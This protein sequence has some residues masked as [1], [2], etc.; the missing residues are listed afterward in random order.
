[1][2]LYIFILSA[3]ILMHNKIFNRI[4]IKD[5]KNSPKELVLLIIQSK[6]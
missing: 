5:L 2:S 6:K 4:L 1:M 3:R